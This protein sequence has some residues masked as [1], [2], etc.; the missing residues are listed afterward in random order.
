MELNTELLFHFPVSHAFNM[1]YEFF[2]ATFGREGIHLVN[3]YP[4]RRNIKGRRV[5]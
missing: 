5:D 4:K 2:P 1:N 3:K